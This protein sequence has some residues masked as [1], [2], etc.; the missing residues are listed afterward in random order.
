VVVWTFPVELVSV[1]SV[2]A[3]AVVSAPVGPGA[4]GGSPGVAG[5]FAAATCDTTL[6]GS[7]ARAWPATNGGK[8][9]IRIDVTSR[10]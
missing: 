9:I 3:G 4:A 2:L 1:V 10:E 8:A 5:R 6:A 7:A